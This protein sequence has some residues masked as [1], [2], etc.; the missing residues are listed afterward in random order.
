[1]LVIHAADPIVPTSPIYAFNKIL[2]RT[3]LPKTT[4]HGLRHTHCTSC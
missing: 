3:G 2:D 4:I 1:M